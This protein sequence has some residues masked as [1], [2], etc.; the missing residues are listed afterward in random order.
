MHIRLFSSTPIYP[1][2]VYGMLPPVVPRRTLRIRVDDT[3]TSTI[4]SQKANTL[5]SYFCQP[6]DRFC[7]LRGVSLRRIMDENDTS[8]KTTQGRFVLT[9]PAVNFFNVLDATPTVTCEAVQS[10][11][12]C[13]NVVSDDCSLQGRPVELLDAVNACFD[14]HVNTNIDF[15][16][17]SDL[18]ISSSIL[19]NVQ[20]PSP[21]DV[22]P[23]DVLTSTGYAVLSTATS[24]LHQVFLSSLREDYESFEEEC[25]AALTTTTTTH[26]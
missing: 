20:P 7:K 19:V 21:F 9:V 26:L 24:A 12:K 13:V 22:F 17:D 16:G 5:R 18:R 1:D 15:V 14:F 3:R 23:D 25:A 4:R 2:I 8:N 10:S 11:G 6:V